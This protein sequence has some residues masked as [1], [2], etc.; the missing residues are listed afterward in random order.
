M[1]LEFFT[2]F[3]QKGKYISFQQKKGTFYMIILINENKCRFM[4][5]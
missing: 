2:L 5:L 1:I 3:L 4:L